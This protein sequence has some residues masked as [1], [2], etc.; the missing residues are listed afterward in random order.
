MFAL[1]ITKSSKR[2]LTRTARKSSSLAYCGLRVLSTMRVRAYA[3]PPA[4]LR[5][6]QHSACMEEVQAH[7]GTLRHRLSPIA[8]NDCE[9]VCVVGVIAAA[10]GGSKA[11]AARPEREVLAA[12]H[13]DKHAPVLSF[14]RRA[15]PPRLQCLQAASR[16]SH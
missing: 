2:A 4:Q 15:Q 13:V 6:P 14:H 11:A 7:L 12:V 8:G 10:G 3:T 16:S 9:D 5:S 1:T